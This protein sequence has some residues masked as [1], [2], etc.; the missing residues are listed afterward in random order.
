M[1]N[2]KAICLEAVVEGCDAEVYLNGIPLGRIFGDGLRNDEIA[3]TVNDCIVDGPNHLEV[4]IDPGERP[5]RARLPGESRETA[6][7]QVRAR[8][9]EYEPGAGLDGSGRTLGA[10][11]YE[12]DE[13]ERP[14]P[15]SLA[16]TVILASPYPAPWAWQR[17]EVLTMSGALVGEAT[18]F[19]E[20]VWAAMAQRDIAGQN[21][22][23]ELNVREGCVAFGSDFR[24]TRAD[25]NAMLGDI[26]G[27]PGF[28]MRPL[29]YEDFDFRLVAGGRLVHCVGVDWDPVVRS[30][31]DGEGTVLRVPLLLGRVEGR[32]AWLR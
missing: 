4:L 25:H 16:G 22:L 11:V 18:R 32:L 8:L 12:G 5:S 21:A 29:A 27:D 28:A 14:R 13:G 3:L 6:G 10:V 9:A 20:H 26:F 15:M 31:P 24:R 30:E 23:S 2:L 17:A 7:V 1:T 19:V